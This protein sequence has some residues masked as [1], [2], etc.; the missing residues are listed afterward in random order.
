M[1]SKKCGWTVP[2]RKKRKKTSN[3]HTR[4]PHI[5]KSG[6]RYYDDESIIFQLILEAFAQRE[7][8]TQALLTSFEFYADVC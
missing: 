7:R 2:S 8:V 5:G 4:I 1:S 3:Q 6:T